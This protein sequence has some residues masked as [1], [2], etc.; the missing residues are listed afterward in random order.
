MEPLIER[1][2]LE[3]LG[4]RRWGKLYLSRP[5]LEAIEQK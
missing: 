3:K 1:K 5:I 4:E 2:I